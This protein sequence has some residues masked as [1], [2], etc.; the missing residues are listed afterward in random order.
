MLHK[1][2][3]RGIERLASVKEALFHTY[4]RYGPFVRKVCS[5]C[6]FQARLGLVRP[7]FV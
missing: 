4:L 3:S 1:K 6:R 7:R 2:D 5:V